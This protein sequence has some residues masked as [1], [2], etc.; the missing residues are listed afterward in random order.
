M[1][2]FPRERKCGQQNRRKTPRAPRR[3]AHTRNVRTSTSSPGPHVW[4]WCFVNKLFRRI[5]GLV[6]ETFNQEA[7][8]MREMRPASPASA[9]NPRCATIHGPISSFPG[10]VQQQHSKSL[11]ALLSFEKETNRPV[12]AGGPM[13]QGTAI[14]NGIS[15]R[16]QSVANHTAGL[17]ASRFD[18][19]ASHRVSARSL[20][21]SPA[22]HTAAQAQDVRRR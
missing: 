5:A 13:V 4:L 6:S 20:H 22:P 18:T 8:E 10:P 16:N 2:S 21:P 7:H 15:N 9:D 17:L 12:A 1:L 14:Q 11:L 3:H 19:T